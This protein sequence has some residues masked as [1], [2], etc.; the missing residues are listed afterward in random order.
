VCSSRAPP[1]EISSAQLWSGRS[2]TPP[3][4]SDLGAPQPTAWLQPLRGPSPPLASPAATCSDPCGWAGE[5]TRLDCRQSHARPLTASTSRDAGLHPWSVPPAYFHITNR[6]ST[7]TIY[8]AGMNP[9]T[10]APTTPKRH[11][12]VPSST[13][14][15][16][17]RRWSPLVTRDAPAAWI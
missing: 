2:P 3:S 15:L 14:I 17:R 11:P 12:H 6:R 10:H 8:A 4:S 5:D 16:L 9:W 7:S 13:S 1:T